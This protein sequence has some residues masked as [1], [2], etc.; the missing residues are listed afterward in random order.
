LFFL[1]WF[2]AMG[3]VLWRPTLRGWAEQLALLCLGLP[4]AQS[5][6]RGMRLA[7]LLLAYGG[8]A[9]LVLGHA[10]PLQAG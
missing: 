1:V 9:R 3:M 5:A 7:S 2:A 4:G 8:L 10:A 6:R